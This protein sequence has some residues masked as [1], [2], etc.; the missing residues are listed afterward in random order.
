M[1]LRNEAFLDLE[2]R[3]LRDKNVTRDERRGS[4]VLGGHSGA[5]AFGP[6]LLGFLGAKVAA[7]SPVEEPERGGHDVADVGQAEEHQGDAQDGVED[8]DDLAPLGLGGD[9]AVT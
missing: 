6:L 2:K 7:H 1:D 4:N 8:G 3:P 9:V 5:A